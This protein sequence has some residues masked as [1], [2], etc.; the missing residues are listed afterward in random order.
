MKITHA[1]LAFVL[2]AS[3]CLS[4]FA[5]DSVQGNWQVQSVSSVEPPKGVS[6]TL[7]LGQDNLA[8]L[9]YTL[10]GE[11]Q[12]WRYSYRVDAGKLHLEPATPFGK[13]KTVTYDIKFDEGKLL[14]L[15][16][17]P[18][19]V[20]EEQPETEEADDSAADKPAEPGAEKQTDQPTDEAEEEDTRVPVWVLVKA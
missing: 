3:L 4:T 11:S 1:L 7:A 6:L 17:K 13:P 15:T 8:T 10:A 14:L 16:P 19:P 2:T 9:T 12:S 5:Q 18:E 20:K